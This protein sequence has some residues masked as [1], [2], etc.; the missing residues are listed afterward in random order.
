MIIKKLGSEQFFNATRNISVSIV[1]IQFI[2]YC[3]W[4]GDHE[5]IS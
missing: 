4:N 2:T 3:D 5:G 1:F